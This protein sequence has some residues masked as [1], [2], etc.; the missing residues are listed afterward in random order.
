[1]AG[2]CGLFKAILGKCET[3]PLSTELWSVEEGKVVVKIGQKPD[4][5]PKGGAAYLEGKGL[6][7]P[8]LIVHTDDDKYLSF[9]NRCTHMKRKIDPVAGEAKLRCC[10]VF[11]SKFDYEGKPLSGPAKDPLKR[12]H[13][14]A[15]KGNL[16]VTV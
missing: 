5:I 16:V 6:Q 14:E 3:K 11:H 4:A 10:S 7:E 2:V 15:D 8:L 12:H 13:V 1:M 9:T